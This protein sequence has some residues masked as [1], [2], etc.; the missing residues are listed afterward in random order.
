ML[1]LLRNFDEALATVHS[2]R[3]VLGQPG[4][5]GAARKRLIQRY[6]VQEKLQVGK[7]AR[8]TCQFKGSNARGTD[9]EGNAGKE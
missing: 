4:A 9:G 8:E 2:A 6:K 5:P 1:I 7:L 3:A